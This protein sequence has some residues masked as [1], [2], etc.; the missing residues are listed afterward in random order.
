MESHFECLRQSCTKQGCKVGRKT[1]RKSVR[2]SR[3][4]ESIAQRCYGVEESVNMI[5]QFAFGKETLLLFL[6]S[7][8]EMKHLNLISRSWRSDGS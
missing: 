5:R 6:N 2:N 1:R 7:N 4:G 8:F 3:E